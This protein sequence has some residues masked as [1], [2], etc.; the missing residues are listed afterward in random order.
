MT[1]TEMAFLNS[2]LASETERPAE[3]EDLRKQ[4]M[5]FIRSQAAAR[6]LVLE[7]E[8]EATVRLL[9]ARF[10]SLAAIRTR[11]GLGPSPSLAPTK[12]SV[13]PVSVWIQMAR[14][15]SELKFLQ[16]TID[17]YKTRH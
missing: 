13:P 6:S 2:C 16:A 4:A 1:K 3:A 5:Q 8:F 17:S 7:T 12:S 15:D 11:L 14:V 10:L 9:T